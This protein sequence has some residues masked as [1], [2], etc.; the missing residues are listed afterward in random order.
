[1]TV[2]PP[3]VDPKILKKVRALLAKAASTEFPDE[4][5]AFTAKATELM[6]NYGISESLL[7]AG[8]DASEDPLTGRKIVIPEPHA[9]AKQILLLAC[10]KTMSCVVVVA[11]GNPDAMVY[12]HTSDLERA[13]WMFTSLLA[14]A[15][16][17]IAEM[18]APLGY[19][20]GG[21]EYR[22][23]WILGFASR[24]YDRMQAARDAAVREAD[25][26]ATDGDRAGEAGEG[27][28][29]GGAELVLASREDEAKRFLEDRLGG[30]IPDADP[31]RADAWALGAGYAAGARADLGQTR[32]GPG[33]VA[34]DN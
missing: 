10:A 9:E 31:P 34:I 3:N 30:P 2:D 8:R 15:N 17:M 6:V 14:Q 22:R 21:N 27:A 12:G 19:P 18:Y 29:A 24:V 28:A 23:G 25:K 16:R 5:E 13:E 20:F 1:M 33:R 4:A 11:E 32:V 7:A 26:S